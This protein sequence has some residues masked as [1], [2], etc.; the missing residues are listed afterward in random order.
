MRNLS[1]YFL[2]LFVFFFKIDIK[3]YADHLIGGEMRYNYEKTLI[4][5][6]QVYNITTTIYRDVFGGGAGFDNPF[7]MTVFNLDDNTYKDKTLYLVASRISPIPLND[8]G[9]CAK[10]VPT[11]KFEKLFYVFSD[12]VTLNN[13]G[14]LYVHQ[15]CCR[16]SSITNL[17]SPNQQGS[18]YTSHL[19]REAML[20]NNSNAIFPLAPPVLMCIK[21]NFKYQF[22]A[23]DINGNRLKYYLCDPY[24]GA[25]RIVDKPITASPPPYFS[26]Q[27][28][29]NY[30]F[31]QPFG[32]EVYVE[33]D[34]NS[35]LFKVQSDRV[36]FFTLAVCMDELND[37]DQIIASSKRD[38]LFN[39]SDCIV[40]TA[41]ASV[42]DALQTSRE[43]YLTCK[44][45]KIQFRNQSIDA[46][47]Y[48]WDF[49]V[50]GS[51]SD[52][53]TL[54]EPI[55]TYADS[56][57][58]DVTLIIN[59][60]QT[61]ADTNHI[62]L[63]VY[64]IL[65]ADINY[66]LDCNNQQI[67]LNNS[68]T[69]PSD[70]ITKFT[71]LNDQKIISSKSSFLYNLPVKGVYQFH[72]KIETQKGCKDSTSQSV[73]LI[74]FSKASFTNSGVQ[75][76]QADQ[77]TICSDDYNV[78]FSNQSVNYTSFIWKINNET[79]TEK[80]FTYQFPD[81]GLYK[82]QL[83]VNFNT[84]CSDTA[85]KFITILPPL[86][87]DFS[88]IPTC[89]KTPFAFQIE[90]KRSYDTI[91]SAN[92]NFGDGTISKEI[93]PLKTFQKAQDYF[94][95][96]SLQTQAGCT[97][98][99]NKTIQVLPNPIA[100]FEILDLRLP[101][102]NF[103]FCNTPANIQFKNLSKKSNSYFWL[104]GNNL[105]L[106]EDT[107]INY[108]FQDTGK[109]FVQLISKDDINC[110][111]TMMQSFEILKNLEK[112]DF[113]YT[114][115][116][117]LTSMKLN[118]ESQ[119]FLN[120]ITSYYWYFGNG[121]S[122][123][124]KQPN[125]VY[126]SAGTYNILLKTKT[127]TGCI[128]SLLKSVKVGG[129]LEP[130]ITQSQETYCKK[131]TIIF[132]ASNSKGSFQSYFWE[133]GDGRTSNKAKNSVLYSQEGTY[134]IRL[135]LEDSLCGSFDTSSLV[136]I[137]SIPEIELEDSIKTCASE[138]VFLKLDYSSPF[139][140][141]IWSSGDRD[142]LQ[143]NVKSEIEKVNVK[144]FHKGCIASDSILIIE[145]C[146]ISIP[147]AFTPNGDGINDYYNVLPY[148]V[149][150]FELSIYNKWGKLVF[151][152]NDFSYSWDGTFEGHN[153]LSDNYI[154]YATGVQLDGRPFK[155]Q[156]SLVLL[157]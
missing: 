94:V 1:P 130:I 98:I 121:T 84:F 122:S 126:D 23:T 116:C 129:A 128:D 56:G 50:K 46:Q 95:Q 59:K 110:T 102:S 5:G 93:N 45:S 139:D 132:D 99:V 22:A 105:F 140:S 68:S 153:L 36:G 111:D 33:L 80:N 74:N 7:Y 64:P 38:F 65:K 138:E 71:W 123:T 30:T 29:D 13:K 135:T 136:N 113:S 15:R 27:Y 92:W 40:A 145:D 20:A 69:S 117:A 147:Q 150:R 3:V 88:T 143:L 76:T 131:R 12:T 109:Y 120:D 119:Y 133:F 58:Y 77:Y 17:V 87:A 35:G 25:D 79:K 31:N 60:G 85:T 96:L 103:V 89:Q 144:I 125:V 21:S 118:N 42:E 108:T 19:T 51:S 124:S 8:L 6:R 28:A 52:T 115:N 127:K 75:Q 55:F 78:S 146:D 154:Y 112:I 48:F 67:Q 137:I 54:A 101:D 81:T 82:V 11:V 156:G 91:L 106:S 62:T 41:R 107:D 34:S 37:L 32:G 70:S 114:N 157:K 97:A 86:N 134:T 16:S 49:G 73:E 61:C 152:T 39:V 83:I 47:S 100:N 44:S 66:V 148:N 63:K 104:V 43:V 151:Y 26:V 2:F 14:Y 24:Y 90:V 72:L 149:D 57:T 18:S 141:I 142:T 4:D 155:L 9:A 10:G 53:S